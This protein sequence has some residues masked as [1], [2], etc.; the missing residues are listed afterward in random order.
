MDIEFIFDIAISVAVVLIIFEISSKIYNKI[1]SNK[2][3]DL[4]GK[5]H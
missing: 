4:K 2:K 5:I 1:K 3:E